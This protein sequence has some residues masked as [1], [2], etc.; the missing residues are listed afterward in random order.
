MGANRSAA[1]K[2]DRP[3]ELEAGRE[4][5]MSSDAG[6]RYVAVLQRLPERLE[7]GARELG[8]YG[9]SLAGR[10]EDVAQRRERGP[11]TR[12][13]RARYVLVALKE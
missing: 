8:N 2:D 11:A 12:R 10:R 7:H 6:D 5:G 1:V 13:V 3:H 4:Q 9:P